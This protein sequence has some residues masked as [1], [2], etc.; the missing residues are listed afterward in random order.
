MEII[1]GMESR[2]HQA[3]EYWICKYIEQVSIP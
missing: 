2:F 3:D 1:C